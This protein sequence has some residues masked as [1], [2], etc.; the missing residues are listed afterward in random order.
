MSLWMSLSA[1]ATERGKAWDLPAPAPAAPEL[2]LV[3]IGEAGSPGRTAART[4]DELART[5]AARRR[6]GVPVVLLW[7]GD[8][9]GDDC[10]ASVALARPGVRELARVARAHEAAGGPSFAVLGAHEWR[11]GAPSLHQQAG[12]GPRPWRLPAANYV[13][14]IQPDGASKV[15]SNCRDQ[16]CTLAPADPAA[17]VDIVLLDTAAWLGPPAQGGPLLTAADTSLAQQQALLAAL[18]ATPQDTPRLL[19]THHPIETAGPHGQGGLYPDSAYAL[20]P[21]PLRRAIDL[22][23]FAGALSGH[24]RSLSATADIAD[25]VKR[26]SRFW[27]KRPIFQVVSGGAAHP[28]GAPSGG[29]RSWAYYQSQALAPDLLSNRAGFAEL[30]IGPDA[31]AAQLHQHKRGRWRSAQLLV[32]RERPPHPAETVSPVL[33]PCLRCDPLTPKQ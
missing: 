5:L 24:D 10:D 15:V 9:L 33:D 29:R 23:L 32:P 26:S 3:L 25:G 4:A 8:V 7:L 13:V 27:L 16:V 22:G 14:R 11:C 2:S 1:C 18:E 19:V 20:H 6:D 21:E 17:L 31:Y 30:I 28:D 12:P